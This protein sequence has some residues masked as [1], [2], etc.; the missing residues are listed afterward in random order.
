M[1]VPTEDMMILATLVS[2]EHGDRASS[3]LSEY[4]D[5]LV[6][7]GDDVSASLWRK[8]AAFWYQEYADRL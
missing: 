4:I 5:Q 6:V 1:N 8:I 3:F 7:T 2:I